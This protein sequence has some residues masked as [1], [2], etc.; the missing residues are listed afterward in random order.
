MGG[1][2]AGHS[3]AVVVGG[4]GLPPRPVQSEGGLPPRP[5]QSE[6][7]LPPQP[8]Q[9]EGGLAPRRPPPVLLRIYALQP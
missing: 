2:P 3:F 6:G 8:V 7:G 4:G 5:V 1:R 9:S